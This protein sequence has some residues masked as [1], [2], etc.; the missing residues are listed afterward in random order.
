MES[1]LSQASRRYHGAMQNP[2]NLRAY[3]EA[4][5]VAIAVYLLTAAFP[6]TERYGLVA[7]MRRA[8]VS[9]GSNVAEGGGRQGNRA[10]V[11]YLH[12]SLGSLNELAFQSELAVGLGHCSD[13]QLLEVRRR[14]RTQKADLPRSRNHVM[15]EAL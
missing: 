14:I 12:Q 4:R 1:Y 10:L 5:E 2:E 6:V 9:V 11:A 7:Q 15:E 13:E 8:A 3:A